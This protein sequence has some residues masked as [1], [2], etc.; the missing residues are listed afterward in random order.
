LA[1]TGWTQ[2]G[3]DIPVTFADGDVFQ[4]HALPDGTVEISQNGFLVVQ[5]A[6][7]SLS[8]PALSK[9]STP[10]ALSFNQPV[11]TQVKP[12][13]YK[14]PNDSAPGLPNVSLPNS[15]LQQSTALTID[16]TYDRLNRL[17]SATY[18]DG[19]SFHYTYD[20]AGNV[21]ELQKNLGPGTVVTAYTYDTANQLQTATENGVTWQYTYDANGSLVSD[22]IKTYTYD[23][24]NRLTQVTD[25]S[26]VTQLSYNGL[27]QRLSMNAAGV[28]P[29]Y[30]MDGDQP[31]VA[32]SSDNTTL[33]RVAKRFSR[34]VCSFVPR[35]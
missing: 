18:S 22:G 11:F 34:P 4:A 35:L 5:Q 7:S 19:R 29:H 27:G 23:A 32:E 2:R 25:Q 33:N 21:L 10:E 9:V 24:A 30:G 14:L 17:A 3:E 15:P 31:L 20:A 8:Q 16:Y 1:E 6:V 13:S 12:V 26:L 28:I